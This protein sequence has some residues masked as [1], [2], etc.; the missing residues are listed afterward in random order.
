MKIFLGSLTNIDDTSQE[1]I[2]VAPNWEEAEEALHEVGLD[3]M[4]ELS[5]VFVYHKDGKKTIH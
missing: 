2:I 5:E 3:L 1:L 4:G